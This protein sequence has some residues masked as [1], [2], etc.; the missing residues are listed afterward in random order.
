M[1]SIGSHLA[2]DHA[3]QCQ[4]VDTD[5]NDYWTDEWPDLYLLSD[6]EQPD[7]DGHPW[8]CVCNSRDD[9][10]CATDSIGF[11]GEWPSNCDV[12]STR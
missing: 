4:R 9:C 1:Y 7:H 5:A 10:E 2:V 11:G 3:C 8:V 6:T 12:V